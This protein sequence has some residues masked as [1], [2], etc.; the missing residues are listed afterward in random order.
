MVCELGPLALSNWIP[1]MSDCRY[2]SKAFWIG[3]F[4]GLPRIGLNSSGKSCQAQTTAAVSIDEFRKQGGVRV[5]LIKACSVQVPF[6]DGFKCLFDSCFDG[7][8]LDP[9]HV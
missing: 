5:L 8:M 9:K 6:C 4:L 7:F 1:Y 2:N 3:Q